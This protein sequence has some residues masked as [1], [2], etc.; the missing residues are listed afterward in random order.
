[1]Y[2]KASNMCQRLRERTLHLI[3]PY[4]L[5]HNFHYRTQ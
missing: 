3:V 5:L 4:Q 2:C 1:M